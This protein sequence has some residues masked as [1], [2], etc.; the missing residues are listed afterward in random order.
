MVRYRRFPPYCFF[1]SFFAGS[2]VALEEVLGEDDAPLEEVLGEVELPPEAGGVAV[3]LPLALPLALPAG[4]V[5]EGELEELLLAAP[6]GL[7]GE[8]APLEA[9]LVVDGEVD[10]LDEDEPES[11]PR[12]HA[13]TPSATATARAKVVSFMRPPWVEMQ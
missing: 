6:E 1:S 12:S 8:V 3:A 4:G 9:P 7:D 5:P 10:V 2:V 11:G 13:A